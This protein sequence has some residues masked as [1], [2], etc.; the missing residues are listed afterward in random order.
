MDEDATTI[1]N[2]TTF[3]NEQNISRKT[4]IWQ[5]TIQLTALNDK[6]QNNQ[7]ERTWLVRLAR[8]TKQELT[9]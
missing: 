7:L 9:K 6:N 1:C 4:Y 2:Y 5:A 3:N 8:R